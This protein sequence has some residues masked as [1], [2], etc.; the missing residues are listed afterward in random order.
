[1]FCT[2]SLQTEFVYL[3]LKT[4][5][6]LVRY[7]IYKRKLRKVNP[8][9]CSLVKGGRGHAQLPS[10]TNSVD[11]KGFFESNAILNNVHSKTLPQVQ[12]CRRGSKRT[13]RQSPQGHRYFD[14]IVQKWRDAIQD[15]NQPYENYAH[16]L[17]YNERNFPFKEII[18]RVDTDRIGNALSVTVFINATIKKTHTGHTRP[19]VPQQIQD[20][21]D[22][23]GFVRG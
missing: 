9:L 10:A 6:V 14:D 17:R 22:L 4:A 16:M 5:K 7:T 13:K 8:F 12:Y 23:V 21:L 3:I 15:P 2:S 18:E 20:Y 19:A 1:M 11:I